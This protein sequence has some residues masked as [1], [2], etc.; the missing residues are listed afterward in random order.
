MCT[1]YAFKHHRTLVL[2]K[3]VESD[4]KP[5]P[6]TPKIGIQMYTVSH[7]QRNFDLTQ[8]TSFEQIVEIAN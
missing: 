2:R 8:Y 7:F 3:K 1:A 5:L 6:R 4:L